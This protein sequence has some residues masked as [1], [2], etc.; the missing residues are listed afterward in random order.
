MMSTIRPTAISAFIQPG[1]GVSPVPAGSAVITHAFQLDI[2]TFGYGSCDS[3]IALHDAFFVLALLKVG[4]HL[5]VLDPSRQA[6]GQN[7]FQTV[8]DF[9]PRLSVIDS[10]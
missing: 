9:D 2:I 6:V 3:Q 8:T 1:I 5:L 10:Y 7:A 4:Q